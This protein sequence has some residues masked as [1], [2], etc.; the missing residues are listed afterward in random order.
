MKSHRV[1]LFLASFS[2]LKTLY[3]LTESDDRMKNQQKIKVENDEN[4][5]VEEFED[6]YENSFSCYYLK[7][8]SGLRDFC[9]SC[10]SCLR[11]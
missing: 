1:N 10:S 2:H 8:P 3:S 4:S 11:L 9:G 5:R 7:E 6:N